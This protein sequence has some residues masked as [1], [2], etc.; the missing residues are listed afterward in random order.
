[1]ADYKVS[2]IYQG[3]Y[4]S[5]KPNYGDGFTG[6]RME[7]KKF[8]M[9][10][11][12][13]TA[14]I[15]KDASTKLN[16]GARH[17]ELSAVSPEVFESIPD[18][19]LKDVYRLSKIVG[20]E[21]SV[22]GPIVEPSGMSREGFSETNRLAAERQM[23]SAV[24]RSHI[25]KPDGSIPVTFHSSVILPDLITQ[26]GKAPEETYVINTETGSIGKIPLKERSFPSEEKGVDIK[27]ELRQINE[28]QWND[29]RRQLSHYS[30]IAEEEL[31]SSLRLRTLAEAEIKDNKPVLPQEREAINTYNRGVGMIDS[32][33]F[34]LKRAFETAHEKGSETEKKIIEHFYKDITKSA[35]EIKRNPSEVSSALK[36]KE[37]I[38]Q[39]LEILNKIEAPEVY[40]NLNDFSKE[41]TIETISNTALHS[42]K[43]FKEN[44]PIL[45]IENPPAGGAFSR[46]EDLKQIV[47]GSRKKFVEK[48]IEEGI[49]E[50][51]AREA[52]EKLIG[53][54]WDVGHINMIKKYGF[55]NKDVLKET[56]AVAPLVKH[57]HLSD[58]FGFE[59]TE[60]PMGM[61]NVPIK[62]IM[63]K[64]GQQGYDAKKNY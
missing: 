14:N 52:A 27:R 53:V 36:K 1:M 44:S 56:E 17:I 38:D 22:H 11:D 19:Q 48:A 34:D 12:P 10:T 63:Q 59:H 30:Q 16:T 7:L 54:T 4:S 39:G 46:G 51:K 55:E 26:K 41:K 20:A 43:K 64:L 58:N 23:I 8:G 3:G 9:T 31:K 13:R 24:E 47:E 2:D 57:V 61:G 62:E 49:N 35:E 37:I 15:I 40:S 50:K 28:E 42:W 21:V 45:S 6:Y 33:Y 32:C 29:K 5:L 60:L 25:V 18:E